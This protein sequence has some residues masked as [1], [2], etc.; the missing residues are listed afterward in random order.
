MVAMFYGAAAFNQDISNWNVSRVTSLSVVFLGAAAF[1]QDINNWD[2]S[3]VTSMDA[4]FQGAAAFNQ[5][6]SG[7]NVSRV[8]GMSNM[9]NDAAAFDQDLGSWNVS[10]V[11]DMFWM[12][13]G[14]TLSTANYDSLL[15]GWSAI[16][17]Q[18]GVYFSGGNSQYS[19][20]T[21]ADAKAY[22]VST[23]GWIIVDGGE[24]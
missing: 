2:V 8:I 20:G 3:R 24:V 4:M 7:W 22:I 16:P 23:F 13:D 5:D 11:T 14:V 1:N 9:F 10:A 17:L 21:A 15:I 6:I 12:F 19:T 18:D